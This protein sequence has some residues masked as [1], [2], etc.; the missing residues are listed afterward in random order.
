MR[1]VLNQKVDEGWGCCIVVNPL[2]LAAM[3]DRA[4]MDRAVLC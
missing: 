2:C 3:M 4:W 1:K